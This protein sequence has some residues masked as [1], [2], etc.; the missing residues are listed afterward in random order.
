MST[1]GNKIIFFALVQDM[2]TI[3]ELK[4]Y[5]FLYH[6]TCGKTYAFDFTVS[7]LSTQ[8][9]YHHFFQRKLLG[10]KISLN[11]GFDMSQSPFHFFV[12]G[13]PYNGN[14]DFNII[15]PNTDNNII[16]IISSDPI[17]AHSGHYFDPP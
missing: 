10:K 8:D 12:N 3:T 5:N 15:G 11:D 4:V 14:F 2:I 6:C 9:V 16:E 13:V 17:P 7:D 1:K